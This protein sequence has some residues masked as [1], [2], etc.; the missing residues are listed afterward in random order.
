MDNNVFELKKE[1]NRLLSERPEYKKF[2][3][4]LEE[5]LRNAGSS[6]NRMVLLKM[7]MAENVEK[8]QNALK[9]LKEEVSKMQSSSK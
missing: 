7:L 8:L 4:E 5:K 3:E 9:E 6:H 1:I 2:Q